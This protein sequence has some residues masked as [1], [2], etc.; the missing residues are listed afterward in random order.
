MYIKCQCCIH[1]VS[2][3][4]YSIKSYYDLSTFSKCVSLFI[5]VLSAG[6]LYD[7]AS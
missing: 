7:F 5:W 1:V 2:Q 3:K 6:K 4:L